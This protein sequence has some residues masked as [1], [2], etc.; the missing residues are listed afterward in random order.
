MGLSITLGL[1]VFE[2]FTFLTGF[3]IFNTSSALLCILN[4]MG[5]LFEVGMQRKSIQMHTYDLH[6]FELYII[7]I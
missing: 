5:T 1:I 4:R 6:K 2:M 7:F 3:T